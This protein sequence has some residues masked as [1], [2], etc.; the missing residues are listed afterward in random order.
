MNNTAPCSTG[1]DEMRLPT[2]LFGMSRF[3]R[4]MINDKQA[5]TRSIRTLLD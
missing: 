3:F 1:Q 5:F 2:Q 4:L